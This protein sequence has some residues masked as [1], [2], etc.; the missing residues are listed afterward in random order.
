MEFDEIRKR[1]EAVSRVRTQRQAAERRIPG[2]RLS[3]KLRE[4]FARQR[5]AES[6]DGPNDVQGHA[7]D[8]DR[9]QG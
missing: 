8:P 5:P 3:R 4:A 6:G 7:M 2:E 9:R 1:L